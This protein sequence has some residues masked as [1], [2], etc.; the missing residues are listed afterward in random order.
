MSAALTAL[1]YARAPRRAA[2]VFRVNHVAA[3]VGWM[4]AA[5][6]VPSVQAQIVNAGPGSQTVAVPANSNLT[7]AGPQQ[8]VL[9]AS[10]LP[11]PAAR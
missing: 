8:S 7:A 1:T 3:L 10:G 11:W 9:F 5:G 2:P 6:G 4:L